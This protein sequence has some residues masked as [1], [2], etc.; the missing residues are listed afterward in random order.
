MSNLATYNIL[1]G[2]YKGHILAN[3]KILFDKGVDVICLQEAEIPFEEPLNNFL[4]QFPDW[5]VRFFHEGSA[6]NLAIVWNTTKMELKHVEEVLLP[7]PD[8]SCCQRAV[9]VATFNVEGKSFRISNAHLSWEGGYSHRFK[10]LEFLKEE[11][12]KVKVDHEIICGDFNTFAPATF[13][14][15]Q[16]RKVQDVLGDEWVN[17]LPDLKWSCDVSFSYEKDTF[18]IISVILTKLGFKL[19]SCLDY[20]FIKNLK[21]TA[22]EML[23][24]PGSDHRPL[25]VSITPP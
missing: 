22:G 14:N 5:S 24:L 17:A 2:H 10:Q 8:R 19:R 9:Q 6:A 3:L 18:H 20:V 7:R 16:K 15:I 13:R 21:V 4:R 23:D 12:K 1:H 11:L 25:F